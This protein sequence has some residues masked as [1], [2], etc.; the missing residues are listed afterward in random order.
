MVHKAK[1]FIRKTGFAPWVMRTAALL[2]CLTLLCV[3]LLPDVTAR[4]ASTA[5]G[6]DSARVAKFAP[7][8]TFTYT[9]LTLSAENKTGSYV[10]TVN[11]RSEVSVECTVQLTGLPTD[12]TPALSVGD[13]KDVYTKDESNMKF[14]LRPGG[15]AACTLTLTAGENAP[16]TDN[17][18]VT[19]NVLVEQV[20]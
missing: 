7:E 11:N 12:V 20:D 19:V 2:I 9:D 13:G 10:F 16:A 18:T 1:N 8:V 17:A 6:S 5:S 4:F 15:A 3:A 14:S